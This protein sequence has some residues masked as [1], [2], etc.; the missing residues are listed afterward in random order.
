MEYYNA[1]LY[2]SAALALAPAPALAYAFAPAPA[3]TKEII[4]LVAFL[5]SVIVTVSCITACAQKM[6][7]AINSVFVALYYI[8]HFAALALVFACT[9]MFVNGFT[10]AFLDSLLNGR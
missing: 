2:C 3:Q 10:F 7:N 5:V 1:S 6:M 8:A 4:V 9:F